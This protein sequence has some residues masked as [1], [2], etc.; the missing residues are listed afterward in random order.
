MQN[1]NGLSCSKG[2]GRGGMPAPG[3]VR[4]VPRARWHALEW[5]GSLYTSWMSFPQ[6]PGRPCL[7]VS[8]TSSSAYHSQELL[9]P[10]WPQAHPAAPVS[11]P[12]LSLLDPPPSMV[13]LSARRPAP[14]LPSLL[15]QDVSQATT[16]LSSLISTA[17]I[18]VLSVC[19]PKSRVL[20]AP[21][22]PR[23][24]ASSSRPLAGSLA[25]HPTPHPL[26]PQQATR[27]LLKMDLCHALKS[28][29]SRPAMGSGANF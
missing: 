27:E 26:Y 24:A 14:P 22:F 1:P 29:T 21:S 18:W 28:L 25:S 8:L 16:L 15:P 3:S 5:A 17:M 7:L 19:L 11:N 10:P 4:H 2:P 23:T 12:P 9:P 20:Q 13:L 6:L